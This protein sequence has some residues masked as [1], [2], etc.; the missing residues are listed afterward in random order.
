MKKKNYIII[1]TIIVLVIGGCF[2]YLRIPKIFPLELEILL[3]DKKNYEERLRCYANIAVKRDDLSICDKYLPGVSEMDEIA[4][5]PMIVSKNYCYLWIATKRKD[6]SV[7]D[8]MPMTIAKTTCY[9]SMAWFKKDT[10]ICDKI[11]DEERRYYCY[12]SLKKI[13]LFFCEKLKNKGLQ[14]WCREEYY[15]R[16]AVKQQ[17]PLLCDKILVNPRL[18]KESCYAQ[19]ASVKKDI[20]ICENFSSDKDDCYLQLAQVKQDISIC[21]KITGAYHKNFCLTDVKAK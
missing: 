15:M 3:C 20:S 8:K 5:S 16:E 17:D 7:C 21:A 11:Q 1:V 6:I 18:S 10:L 14:A 2:I 9:D 12:L 13:D 19:V 4:R